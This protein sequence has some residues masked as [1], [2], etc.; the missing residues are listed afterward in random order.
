M[1]PINDFEPGILSFPS[2]EAAQRETTWVENEVLNYDLSTNQPYT[3][4]L[5]YLDGGVLGIPLTFMSFAPIATN[6]AAV[7][8][9]RRHKTSGRIVPFQTTQSDP[10]LRD[11]SL[12]RLPAGDAMIRAVPP[13]FD[14]RLTPTLMAWL[15][16]A[17]MIYMATGFLRVMQLQL[18]NP[19]AWGWSAAAAPTNATRNALARLS[20]RRGTQ[21]IVQDGAAVGERLLGEVAGLNGTGLQRYLE[22]A[23][24][25]SATTGLSPQAKADLLM[26]VAPRLGLDVGGQAVVSGGRIL[27]IAKDGKTAFQIDLDGTITFG[28]FNTATLDIANATTIRPLVGQ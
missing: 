15:N 18:L 27:L 2:L 19:L 26:S 8:L 10:R 23:R 11:P 1:D 16:E 17:Q 9:F 6:T 28:R 25:L 3:F 20:L 4:T 7:M 12:G 24:R 13:R 14:P 21:V 5:L 22:F